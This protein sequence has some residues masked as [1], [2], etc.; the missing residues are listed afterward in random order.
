MLNYKF[1]QYI[2]ANIIRKSVISFC[3]ILILNAFVIFSGLAFYN[4]T[5]MQSIA[6][7]I[8]DTY[9]QVFDLAADYAIYFLNT[10]TRESRLGFKQDGDI[11]LFINKTGPVKDLSVGI[12]G[13]TNKLKTIIPDHLQL[14]AA[15]EKSKADNIDYGYFMPMRSNYA[16]FNKMNTQLTIGQILSRNRVE[17]DIYKHLERCKM[18]MSP[19]YFED[20]SGEHLRT[21]YYPVYINKKAQTL[22]VIDIK[23]SFIHDFIQKN[24]LHYF[25]SLMLAKVP[26]HVSLPLSLPCEQKLDNYIGVDILDFFIKFCVLT[27]VISLVILCLVTCFQYRSYLLQHDLMTMF[28]RRDYYQNKLNKFRCFSMLIIDIDNFKQINDHYGHLKGDQVIKAIAHKINNKMRKTDIAIRWGGE[29]FVLLFSQMSASQLEAKAESI[30][31]HIADEM[32]EQLPITISIGGICIEDSDF[33]NAYK[34]A[35]IAL[36]QAKRAGRNQVVIHSNGSS[37]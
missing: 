16:A 1:T 9:T 13:I 23:E 30:R 17:I 33:I 3:K 29:E 25:S 8:S 18:K 22:L 35:D 26:Q 4:Y 15:F 31:S 20:Y 10:E 37:E 21:I 14:V 6:D 2:D 27:L 32:I 24:N 7:E 34:L 19:A 5:Q 12:Q 36:Y 28:Y 11:G